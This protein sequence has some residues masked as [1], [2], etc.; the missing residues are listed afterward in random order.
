MACGATEFFDLI[1]LTQIK[2]LV[3]LIWH[4]GSRAAKCNHKLKK[5]SC[6]FLRGGVGKRVK[7]LIPSVS[8][9]INK[10]YQKIFNFVNTDTPCPKKIEVC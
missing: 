2:G 7:M 4:A 9:T 1:K 6:I 5:E 8:N 10:N 3:K